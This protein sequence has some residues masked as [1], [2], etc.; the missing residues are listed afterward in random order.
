MLGLGKVD[1][2]DAKISTTCADAVNLVGL[3]GFYYVIF[4]VMLCFIYSFY[5]S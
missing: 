5:F 1:D 2:D 3:H 4:M